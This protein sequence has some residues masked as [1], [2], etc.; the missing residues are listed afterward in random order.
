MRCSP[1]YARELNVDRVGGGKVTVVLEG[2]AS[3]SECG[4]SGELVFGLVVAP[5]MGRFTHRD[6]QLV[7]VGSIFDSAVTWC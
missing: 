5:Q 3:S 4:G 6:S 7:V 1:F 2:V